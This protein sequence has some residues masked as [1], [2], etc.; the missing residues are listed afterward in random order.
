MDKRL[1]KFL[2]PVVVVMVVL[3]AMM[4][5]LCA[6]P[7][8][9]NTVGHTTSITGTVPAPEAVTALTPGV[10]SDNAAGTTASIIQV[11]D[12]WGNPA[13]INIKSYAANL[14]YNSGL[15][16]VLGVRHKASF[17]GSETIDNVAGITVFDG[18]AAAGVPC[19]CD[20]SFLTLRLMGTALQ[21][22]TATLTFTDIRDP[23]DNLINQSTPP[24][25]NV[26]LRGDA[27][28][29]GM[30]DIS[31]VLYICQYLIGLRNVG[32][33]VDEVHPVNAA[34]VRYDGAYDKISISDA[35]FIAQYLAGLRGVDYGLV[36]G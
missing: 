4:L 27:K 22:A 5:L 31:D 21:Q 11:R 16:N 26:F 29:D 2:P 13:V 10:D 25:Q 36:P 17:P 6:V 9:G 8:L 28:A 35:L 23:A 32:P 33:G 19:P 7:V 34:S 30:V 15:I 12:S 24:P 3:V 18:A 20:L 1:K 14:S